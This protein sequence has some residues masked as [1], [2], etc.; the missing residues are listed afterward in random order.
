[1]YKNKTVSKNNDNVLYHMYVNGKVIN[2]NALLIH[3][4]DEGSVKLLQ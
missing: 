4:G 1:M 3:Q 2:N